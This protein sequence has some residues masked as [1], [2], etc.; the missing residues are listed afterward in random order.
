M[1]AS[2]TR[3]AFGLGLVI[4]GTAQAV[5]ST[6]R[7]AKAPV[8]YGPRRKLNLGPLARFAPGLVTFVDTAKV[9]VKRDAEGVRAMSGVCTHLGCTV[10]QEGEGYVCP[11]HG[12]RYDNEGHVTSGPAPEALSFL[13]LETDTRGNL[14]VDIASPIAP[15]KRLPVV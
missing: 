3:R 8:S 15:N 12:S 7:F 1:L 2:V 13:K 4:V 10:R 5:W 14:I 11:C 6:F 9:F